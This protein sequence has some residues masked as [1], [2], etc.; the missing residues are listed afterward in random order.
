MKLRVGFRKMNDA[1]LRHGGIAVFGGW[2]DWGDVF[3]LRGG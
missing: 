3:A 1:L 2:G